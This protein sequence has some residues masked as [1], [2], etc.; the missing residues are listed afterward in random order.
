M[1]IL[2]SGVSLAPI[3]ELASRTSNGYRLHYIT[4]FTSQQQATVKF[5]GVFAS[6]WNSVDFTPQCWIQGTLAR[7][8]VDLITPFMRVVIQTTRYFAQDLLRF[9]LQETDEAFLFIS[10]HRCCVR[11]VTSN[12]FQ[13]VW[14]SVSEDFS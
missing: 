9:L 3:P 5:Y 7:D 4:K 6:H 14:H 1:R 10:Q 2:Q 11:T 13:F 12:C 8:S